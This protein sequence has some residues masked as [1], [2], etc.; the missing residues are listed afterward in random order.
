MTTPTPEEQRYHWT[1]GN[2]FALEAMKALLWLNGVSAAALL[3]LFGGSHPH[4]VTPD[5]AYAIL[6]FAIGAAFSVFMFIWAYFV[7]LH[8]SHHGI[9]K[10]WGQ[11]INYGSYAAM[12]LPL[13]GFLLGLSYAYGAITTALGG[14]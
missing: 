5:F 12:L 6:W 3:T 9:P 4:S 2:K 10:R 8:F 1:E 11:W 7:Q 13:I 14:G